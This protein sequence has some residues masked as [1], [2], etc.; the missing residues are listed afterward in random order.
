MALKSLMDFHIA[1]MPYVW[2][3]LIDT[4]LFLPFYVHSKYSI[5]VHALLTSLALGI[6]VLTSSNSW[7]HGIPP[8]SNPMH[9][10]KLFGVII[11]GVAT[12]QMI[13]GLISKLSKSSKSMKS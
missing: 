6:T 10:H 2:S 5:P 12:L 9:F 11:F 7:T 1:F 13:L 8:P 3:I 4:A